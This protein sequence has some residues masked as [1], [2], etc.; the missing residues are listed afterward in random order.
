MGLWAYMVLI[1][2]YSSAI[3]VSEDS[4]LRQSIRNFAIKESRLLDS[5]WTAQMEQEIER[6]VITHKTESGIGWQKR[7]EFNLL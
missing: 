4:K 1:G 7:P 6:R 3:S 5:I 2:I